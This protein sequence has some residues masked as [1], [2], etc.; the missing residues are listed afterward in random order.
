MLTSADWTQMAVDLAEVRTDNAVS[1]AIRRAGSTLTAQ[2]VRVAKM[3]TLARA[4]GGEVEQ[5]QQSVVVLGTTSLDIQPGDRFNAGGVLYEVVAV[6][7][8]RRAGTV[9]EATAVQ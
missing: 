5:A 4:A 8:N 7:P 6:R 3:P 1:V 9:A 2:T